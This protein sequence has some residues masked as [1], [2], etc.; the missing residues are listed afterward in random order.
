M[1][2][3]SILALCFILG[4]A[5]CSSSNKDLP[6]GERLSVLKTEAKGDAVSSKNALKMISVS[7]SVFM[8][9]WSQTS[10]LP[11]HNTPNIKVSKELKEHLRVSF[12]NGDSKRSLLLSAPVISGRHLFVQDVKGTVYAFDLQDGKMLFKQKL[13]PLNENDTDNSSNGAGLAV[14]G[15]KLY[16][17]AGFGGVFSLDKD[18]GEILWRKDLKIPLRTPP[19]VFKNRLFVLSID[20][21][22]FA[23]NT[24]NGEELWHYDVF[25]EET[26]L[27]GG[28]SPAYDEKSKVLVAAFSNGQLMALDATLGMPVWSND[29]IGSTNFGAS[30]GIN[31]IK[32]APIIYKDMV[33]SIGSNGMMAAL[34]LETGEVVW[35]RSISGGQTPFVNNDT[36]YTVS[37]D[38]M[39]IALDVQSG[40]TLW[41][42]DL[43]EDVPLKK[44]KDIYLTSPIMAEGKILATA[45]NGLVYIINPKTGQKENTFDLKE[46]VPFGPIAAQGFVVFT[47]SDAKLVVFK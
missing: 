43:L 42:K 41:F 11:T 24:E 25:A 28:A 2:L 13:K 22:I 29:I 1:K 3:Q 27:A 8:E 35:R 32:A 40:Q 44:R 36:L 23:L 12:K 5:A 45:S 18:T 21:R 16:A 17:L 47:T 37:T 46:K 7:D 4:I 19:T 38:Q 15:D 10:A 6:K 34:K 33:V 9:N 20:N 14:Q 30:M 31:A 26:T 39:L